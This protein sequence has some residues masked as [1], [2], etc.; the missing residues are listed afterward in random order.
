MPSYCSPANSFLEKL[1]TVQEFG[2]GSQN[3]Q[4]DLGVEAGRV[5]NLWE[6]IS[7]PGSARAMPEHYLDL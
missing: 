5:G 7:H 1:V 6:A 2:G 3:I 4:N